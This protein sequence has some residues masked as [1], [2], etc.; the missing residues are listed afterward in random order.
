MKK[1]HKIILIC[2]LC[3]VLFSAFCTTAFAQAIN[4][5]ASFAQP[6]NLLMIPRR[7]TIIQ[8]EKIEDGAYGMIFHTNP[9]YKPDLALDRMQAIYVNGTPR[10][11]FLGAS[12]MTHLTQKLEYKY[13]G[14]Y[15]YRYTSFLTH[16]DEPSDPHVYI[17]QFDYENIRLRHGIDA[18][19]WIYYARSHASSKV[20]VYVKFL[21]YIDNDGWTEGE[22]SKVFDFSHTDRFTIRDIYDLCVENGAY[23]G[24]ERGILV[25]QMSITNETYDGS[26][27]TM[28]DEESIGDS[29]MQ[30]MQTEIISESPLGHAPALLEWLSVAVGGFFDTT[31][32]AIGNVN[33]KIGTLFI[34][35]LSCWI[36]VLFV[37][38][39]AGG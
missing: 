34:I 8:K 39:F 18:N 12:V 37:K 19:T 13:T 21:T 32:F 10:G 25:R 35:P 29:I 31:I 6:S 23:T 20:A 2:T 26:L 11:D 4:G 1:T 38:K 17:G 15:Y 24:D 9:L 27:L 22:A 33:I 7:T 14:D 5:D 36:V 28:Q 30:Q 3:C 16:Y